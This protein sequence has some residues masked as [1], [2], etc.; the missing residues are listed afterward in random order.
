LTRTEIYGRVVRHIEEYLERDLPDLRPESRL[1][2][3]APGLDSLKIFEMFLYL[4]DCFQLSFDESLVEQL[5]TLDDLVGYI[6]AQL[7]IQAEGA[8]PASA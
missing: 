4:E 5:G 3:L 2:N 7:A 6:A 8:A 1:A